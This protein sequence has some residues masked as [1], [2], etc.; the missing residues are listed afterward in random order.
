MHNN[1]K[2]KNP[3]A[4]RA[5]CTHISCMPSEGWISPPHEAIFCCFVLPCFLFLLPVELVKWTALRPLFISFLFFLSPPFLPLGDIFANCR[6][7]P[8]KKRNTGRAGV[9]VEGM[10]K[11]KNGIVRCTSSRVVD[12]CSTSVS[13]SILPHPCPRPRP[14]LFE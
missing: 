11:K 7:C 13:L 5:A 8:W 2:E 1:K 6:L 12:C 3:C 9:E 10:K 14:F 4:R